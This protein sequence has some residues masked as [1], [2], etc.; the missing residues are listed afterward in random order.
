MIVAPSSK[1]R[2]PASV[3]LYY[4]EDHQSLLGADGLGKLTG[5]QRKGV[6]F[7]NLGQRAALELTQIAALGCSRSVAERFSQL[8]EVA[9][10]VL[11]ADPSRHL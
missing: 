1:L 6:V 8:R 7:K 9:A 3:V 4:L 11:L 2:N 5:F 10:L